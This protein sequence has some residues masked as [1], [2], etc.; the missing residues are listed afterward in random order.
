MRSRRQRNFTLIE[1]L[2]VITI[3]SILAAMLLP[4]LSAAREKARTIVCLTQLRQLHTG[5]IF[6]ADDHDG[7]IFPWADRSN[8][9][10]G[11]GPSCAGIPAEP[12]W[13]VPRL[14]DYV[15]DV[16]IYRCPADEP[17]EFNP[18][19]RKR[20]RV[21][22]CALNDPVRE[23]DGYSYWINAW[24]MKTGNARGA[25]WKMST[26]DPEVIWLFGHSGGEYVYTQF[27]NETYTD[28]YAEQNGL[29]VQCEDVPYYYSGP[30]TYVTKRHQVGFNS[31]TMGGEAIWH[32]WGSTGKGHWR[33]D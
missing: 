18:R 2:V 29:P 16:R 4:A 9:P 27:D 10:L 6:Y 26:Y 15:E 3:I 24:G 13:G 8:G 23:K 7:A 25:Y 28:Y 30:H 11:K 33:R 12:N 19:M 22:H 21:P 14:L 5:L 31:V 20:S 17:K 1:L 32:K